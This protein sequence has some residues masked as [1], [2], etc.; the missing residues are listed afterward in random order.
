M[1]LSSYAYHIRL[2]IQ[3]S[4]LLITN[5]QLCCP[6]DRAPCFT[7]ISPAQRLVTIRIPK[8][9]TLVVTACLQTTWCEESALILLNLGGTCNCSLHLG[10]CYCP[11]F[12]IN[13]LNE[14]SRAPAASAT[15]HVYAQHVAVTSTPDSF[16]KLTFFQQLCCSHSFSWC[17]D[18]HSDV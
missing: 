2:Y 5:W 7:Q 18:W 1:I 13:K 11:T 8:V 6:E 15:E 16:L 9:A 3:C 14:L 4:L 10:S 12:E 17:L